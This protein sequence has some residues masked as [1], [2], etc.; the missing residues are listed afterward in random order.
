[1]PM[2]REILDLAADIPKKRFHENPPRFIAL[3][4]SVVRG[5]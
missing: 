5:W 4:L 3:F 1:M 2:V